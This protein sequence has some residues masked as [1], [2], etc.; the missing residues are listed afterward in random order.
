MPRRKRITFEYLLIHGLNDL[1]ADAAE[2]AERIRGIRCKVNLIPFNPHEGSDYRRPP[3]RVIE[4]F[5]ETLRR[6]GIQVH[7]RR[8][9][10]D[11]IQAACGQ[12]YR[13]APDGGLPGECNP[14]AGGRVSEDPGWG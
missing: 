13:A 12:L 9:R 6:Q 1:A 3:D 11:D 5:G 10:G 2:L 7:V 4:R 14:P 8:P